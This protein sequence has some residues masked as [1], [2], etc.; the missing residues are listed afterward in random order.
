MLLFSTAC[1]GALFCVSSL[2]ITSA[3]AHT[4][5][6]P[7]QSVARQYTTGPT[8]QQFA[9]VPAAI[10]STTSLP[11]N[12]AAA[13]GALSTATPSTVG[14][15]LSSS[16]EVPDPS[17][18]DLEPIP[19]PETTYRGAHHQEQP[20]QHHQQVATQRQ[21]AQQQQQQA[22]NQQQ[23]RQTAQ[24]QQQRS[25]SRQHGQVSWSSCSLVIADRL[26]HSWESVFKLN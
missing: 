25:L 7:Q 22:A 11:V 12:I 3:F 21:T 23:Q 2:P 26:E 10:Q 19:L 1:V 15:P 24:Q 9:A 13:G 6:P 17:S 16:I 20:A 4:C 5:L 14:T 8:D 18:L